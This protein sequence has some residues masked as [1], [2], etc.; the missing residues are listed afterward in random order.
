M[1][2]QSHHVVPPDAAAKFWAKVDRTPGWGPEGNCW[3]WTG[4]F[5]GGY[6]RFC[7]NGKM[8]PAGRV[9][10]WIAHGHEPKGQIGHRC[11]TPGCVNPAHLVEGAT[12]L[13]AVDGKKSKQV[14]TQLDLPALMQPADVAVYASQHADAL[15]AV[16][17]SSLLSELGRR[18]ADPGAVANVAEELGKFL[19]A[20]PAGG[21]GSTRDGGN[22]LLLRLQCDVNICGDGSDEPFVTYAGSLLLKWF[23]DGDDDGVIHYARLGHL[24][25]TIVHHA[26]HLQGCMT[27]LEEGALLDTYYQLLK[28][29]V[30]DAGVEWAECVRDTDAVNDEPMSL[31]V[32][33][34]L[35]LAEPVASLPLHAWVMDVLIEH[36]DA[37]GRVMVVWCGPAGGADQSITQRRTQWASAGLAEVTG[38][39]FYVTDMEDRNPP[40]PQLPAI[41][42]LL[43][44]EQ[45][46]AFEVSDLMH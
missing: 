41:D 15:T 34:D 36:F 32:I 27:E 46:K 7:L 9:A 37:V 13:Y 19:K 4:H 39:D 28:H 16:G 40:M 23:S 33:E 17:T 44:P 26:A 24:R 22:D 10:L 29:P 5:G 2:K 8:V 25:F 11:Q 43:T 30:D 20:P 35:T 6:P 1:T 38:T 42:E 45:K 12:G 14:V 31:L 18:I 21:A 3:R